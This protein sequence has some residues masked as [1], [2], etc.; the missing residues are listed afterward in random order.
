LE[1]A[2]RAGGFLLSVLVA[3]RLGVEIYGRYA[4][5]LAFFSAL[6][7]LGGAG[8]RNWLVVA[9]ARGSKGGR[10]L[11]RRGALG[12]GSLVV[13]LWLGLLGASSLLGYSPPTRYFVLAVCL[14]AVPAAMAWSADGVLL[15]TGRPAHGAAGRAA[16]SWAKLLVAAAIMSAGGN[17]RGLVYAIGLGE[18]IGL[19]LLVALAL[20]VLDRREDASTAPPMWASLPYTVQTLIVV[21]FLRTD[22]LMLSVMKG[23]AEVGAYGAAYRMV[24]VA[25]LVSASLG[26]VALRRLSESSEGFKSALAEVGWLAGLTGLLAG[27]ALS[28]MGGPVVRSVFGEEFAYSG[29]VLGILGLAAFPHFLNTV[30]ARALW[31][32]GKVWWTVRVAATNLVLNVTLNLVLVPRW[33]ARGASA[34]TVLTLLAGLAQNLWYL[35]VKE[36]TVPVGAWLWRG[37]AAAAI[38]LALLRSAGG[39]LH[40]GWLIGVPVVYCLVLFLLGE[41]TYPGLRS[42][43]SPGRGASATTRREDPEA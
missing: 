21:L 6:Q 18:V 19:A 34:A 5:A 11:L 15:G 13:V 36:R 28:G 29:R 43:V 27:V 10:E 1:G 7:V 2:A 33:G 40:P 25:F 14:A 38:T 35:A 30:S 39:N 3:R 20:K 17:L 4:L 41:R 16:A 12:S 31:A 24:E 22:T 23:E 32:R 9:I 37:L 8:T 26:S 42:P